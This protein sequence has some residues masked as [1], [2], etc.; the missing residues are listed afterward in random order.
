MQK[1][2]LASSNLFFMRILPSGHTVCANY[3]ISLMHTLI[4]TLL[5][6]ARPQK[7]FIVKLET[8]KERERKKYLQNKWS[9]NFF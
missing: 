3:H 9:K 4:I 8:K 2:V 7:S 1:K 5:I 6:L